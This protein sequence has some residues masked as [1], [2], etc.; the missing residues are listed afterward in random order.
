MYTTPS[1]RRYERG[2]SR[3]RRGR[4]Q[5]RRQGWIQHTI[6]GL[7]ERQ[8]S[9]EV[10]DGWN[11]APRVLDRARFRRIFCTYH[12]R[13]ARENIEYGCPVWTGESRFIVPL[14]S[15]NSTCSAVQDVA[16]WRP[17][18]KLL[19]S[20]ATLDAQKFSAYF[21]KAPVFYVPGRRFPVDILY[22]PQPE[23]NYLHAAITTVFQIH[24][25]QPRGDILVFFTGQEEI[26]AAA[27][28][29][30]ETMRTLS[31][32]VGELM[33]CPIYANLPSEMQAKIFEPTPPGARKVVLATNIA[34][35]SITIDGV[36]F[37]IDPGV[38][39]QD[40]YNPKT[41]MFALTIVPVSVTQKCYIFILTRF[42]SA[43]RLLPIKEQDVLG[44][45]VQERPSVYTPNGLIRTKWMIILHR[46]SSAPT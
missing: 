16:R 40:S 1:S 2:C 10:Y 26:E 38:V 30:E 21:D 9:L 5:I 32:K 37:V 39:K 3:C 28:N 44:A 41:G 20:S 24:T 35:T 36:V 13:G 6:R 42:P 22:T 33:I 43:R 23:A 31:N 18:L 12:R 19:I 4:H 34:E 15:Q 25:T 45:W 17:E 27:E 7:H 29:L 46:K 11:A 14:L 8:D